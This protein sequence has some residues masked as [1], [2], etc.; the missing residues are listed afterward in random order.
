MFLLVLLLTFLV[1]VGVNAEPTNLALGKPYTINIEA[2]SRYRDFGNLEAT[3]GKRGLNSIFNAAWQGH[4]QKEYRILVLDLGATYEIDR[5]EMGFIQDQPSNVWVPNSL[6]LAVSDDGINWQVVNEEI[7]EGLSSENQTAIRTIAANQATGRY[8]AVFFGVNF[9]VFFDEIEVYGN[10]VSLGNDGESNLAN[11]DFDALY[12]GFLSTVNVDYFKA[13]EGDLMRVSEE[14]GWAHDILL[15]Y[16]Q[17]SGIVWNEHYALPY[18]AYLDE[19]LQPKDWFFDTYL[20][21]ALTAPGGYNF[22]AY[23][24]TDKTHWDWW[25]DRVFADG[26]GFDAFNKAV[27]T[28]GQ[29]LGDEE[30][31]A[32]VIVMIPYPTELPS[33]PFDPHNPGKLNPDVVGMEEAARNRLEVVKEY[34]DE[35][36]TRWNEKNYSRLELIGFY[37]LS[38]NLDSAGFDRFYLP[39]IGAYVRTCGLKFYWIPWYMAPGYREWRELGFDAVMM[40]PN[41]MFTDIPNKSRF[42]FAAAEAKKYQLGLE[43]ESSSKILRSAEDRE[44]YYDYL[45][46]ANTLGY[47]NDILRG[48]YQ[49]VTLYYQAAHSKDPEVRR[50]YDATYEFVK[51][52]YTE[53][54]ED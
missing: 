44:L 54:F 16:D 21:L 40:Q 3:D 51:G 23:S 10:P 52:T 5:V 12:R 2:E 13:V 41:Y 35:V 29:A 14:T 50:I 26:Q 17:A 24:V 33:L 39:D 38:E 15:V 42:V 30:Y 46:A 43:F 25:L 7:Y 34:I 9:W 45:R 6:S 19:D 49:D 1:S 37:W 18:V 32:K 4:A 11:V 27:I 20:F 22:A 53:K 47:G 36:L 48:Y 31:K 28:V 8:V